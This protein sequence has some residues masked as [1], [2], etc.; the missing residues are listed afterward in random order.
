MED[1]R[2]GSLRKRGGYRGSNRTGPA[3][4]P[5][6]HTGGDPGT[7]AR[8][9]RRS[10]HDPA[11]STRQLRAMTPPSGSSS[12][13]RMA[14]GRMTQRGGPLFWP[15]LPG[16]GGLGQL[17]VEVGPGRSRGSF[18]LKICFFRTGRVHA[19]AH[20]KERRDEPGRP[21]RFQPSTTGPLPAH[22]V[23]PF[24]QKK[25]QKRAEPVRWDGSDLRY[26]ERTMAAAFPA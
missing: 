15:T 7:A 6:L 13:T 12:H 11:D 5:R 23:T 24:R 8:A 21:G 16:R 20:R 14:D 22:T 9:A 4:P 10:V 18:G 19:S 2:P 25:G 26:R 1:T 3:A 17:P